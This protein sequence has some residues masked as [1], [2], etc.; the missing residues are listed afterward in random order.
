M[1]A[2]RAVRC[3]MHV[4]ARMARSHGE[5]A[6][7]SGPCWAVGVSAAWTDCGSE[8]AYQGVLALEAGGQ[9]P[10]KCRQIALQAKP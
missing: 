7:G 1:P 2:T 4:L 10:A 9:H 3:E 5:G 8:T 6:E